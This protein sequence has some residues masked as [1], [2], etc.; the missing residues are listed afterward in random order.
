M[1]MPGDSNNEKNSSNGKTGL[2]VYERRSILKAV[3][4]QYGL[5]L[6]QCRTADK[7]DDKKRGNMFKNKKTEI[8]KEE[9][10]DD[11]YLNRLEAGD[12]DD[13]CAVICGVIRRGKYKGYQFAFID[14]DRKKGLQEFL[15]TGDRKQDVEHLANMQYIE[16]NGY[17]RDERFHI[18]IILEPDAEIAAKGADSALGIEINT[19]GVMFGLGSP[20]HKGLNYLQYGDADVTKIRVYNKTM[21]FALQDHIM[22]MCEKNGVKYF[23]NKND[24]SKA[25]FYNACTA[26]LEEPSTI[27]EEGGRHD[28]D[29]IQGCSYFWRYKDGWGLLTDD[30]RYERL[31]EWNLKHC[32]PPLPDNELD[33]IWKWIIKEHR[34]KRDK[35]HEEYDLKTRKKIPNEFN[36]EYKFKTYK[37]EIQAALK[38]NF[39]VETCECYKWIVGDTKRNV[40]YKAHQ[41]KYKHF[42]EQTNQSSELIFL[43]IDNILIQCLPIGVTKHEDPVSFGYEDASFTIEFKD[44]NGKRFTLVRKPIS[45]IVDTLISRGYVIPSSNETDKTLL[46]ILHAIEEDGKMIID[47][48]VDFEGYYYFEGQIHRSPGLEEFHPPRT[49]E[50]CKDTCDFIE[51]LSDFYIYKDKD[52][53]VKHDRRNCLATYIKWTLPAPFNFAMKQMRRPYM[54]PLSSTG[55]SSGGKSALSDIP[56]YIHGHKNSSSSAGLSIYDIPAGSANT[57]AKFGAALEHTT[58]PIVISEFG[59]IEKY[60]RDE[61]FVETFKNAVDTLISRRGRKNSLFD[62]PFRSLSP[63]VLNGN[64]RLS[65]KPEVARRAHW[66]SYTQSDKHPENDPRTK[67]YNKLIE[68]EAYKLKT[69]G[70]WTINH[71]WN[72]QQELL[73]SKRYDSAQLMKLLI[74]RFYKF[75]DVERPKWLDGWIEETAL[76]EIGV[77]EISTVRSI[78]KNHTN[79]II[80]RHA[81]LLS[82]DN[83]GVIKLDARVQ[84]CLKNDLFGFATESLQVPET[85]LIDSSILELFE[86]KL[87]DMTLTRLGEMLGLEYCPSN[88]GRFLKT[89]ANRLKKILLGES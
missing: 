1:T 74:V 60:G 39:W 27:I 10:T 31:K 11:Y 20:H 86:E 70:D 51:R 41:E 23:T 24:K 55:E 46:V 33:D 52:G 56:L 21:A 36:K 6:I 43:S 19:N 47:E 82:I 25:D 49:K 42:D 57:D 83:Q 17:D 66:S 75:A 88:K 71:L 85:Y 29:K 13:G 15:D 40:I 81:R 34:E 64:S 9:R 35:E 37:E 7:A 72:K 77:D 78:L 53:N 84:L 3:I 30:D 45:R 14:I 28:A 54:K 80:T 4:L 18:P 26:Y 89:T 69:L 58:Y 62:Y 76:E 16:W 65:R 87:P 38:D 44:S 5:D 48:S 68:S 61:K 59:T 50:E 12:Y 22:S 67:D 79:D 32:S 2:T 63:M 73:L 8:L